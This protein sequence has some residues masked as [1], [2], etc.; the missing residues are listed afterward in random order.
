MWKQFFVCLFNGRREFEAPE[1]VSL[2]RDLALG[3]AETQQTAS[4]HA[5]EQ[6]P[7]YLPQARGI[8][9]GLPLIAG[10][11][12]GSVLTMRATV[13]LADPTALT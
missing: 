13:A 5:Y 11:P 2:S 8:Q 4:T 1:W 6:I 3:Q 12:K 7:G 10:Y 9:W